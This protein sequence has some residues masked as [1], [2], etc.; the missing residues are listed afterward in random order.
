MR[1]LT[2]NVKQTN[3]SVKAIDKRVDKLTNVIKELRTITKKFV[4][5]QTKLQT[6][7][8]KSF[9]PNIKTK[10]KSTGGKNLWDANEDQILIQQLTQKMPINDIATAHNRT[11]TAI[12]SRIIKMVKEEIN[13]G[14]VNDDIIR[15]FNVDANFINLVSTSNDI[16]MLLNMLVNIPNIP[17]TQN[18]P[19]ELI[20]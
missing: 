18:I 13:N 17:N 4:K 1:D 3:T 7:Q 15:N 19:N 8:I 16:K 11:P 20:K 2:Q 14:I 6:K 9:N 10:N 12:A 5:Q